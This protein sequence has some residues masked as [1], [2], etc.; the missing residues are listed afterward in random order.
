[1]KT[2]LVG[3]GGCGEN[4]INFLARESRKFLLTALVLNDRSRTNVPGANKKAA[5][6]SP[7]ELGVLAKKM[8]SVEICFMIGGLGSDG[9]KSMLEL[10]RELRKR[11]IMTVALTVFPFSFENL[12]EKAEAHLH[13][14]EENLDAVLVFDNDSLTRNLGCGS[15]LTSGLEAMHCVM[16]DC[17][18]AM[19]P[20]EYNDVADLRAF[21]HGRVYYGIGNSDEGHAGVAE[22]GAYAQKRISS[23]L[24]NDLRFTGHVLQG[25][26]GFEGMRQRNTRPSGCRQRIM[27]GFIWNATSDGWQFCN[28]S[29]LRS[30]HPARLARWSGM[31]KHSLIANLS[32]MPDLSCIRNYR[33]GVQNE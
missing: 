25:D 22:R 10:A 28:Y 9:C 32:I 12:A 27:A 15:S 13:E 11:G 18:K 16:R 14:L 6:Y 23:Q 5:L 1:M 17:L 21:L 26:G 2:A 24:Q 7:Q 29:G 4:T 20:N 31:I 33:C 8:D 3:F 30:A 19:T